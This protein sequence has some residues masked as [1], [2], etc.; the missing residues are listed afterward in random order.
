MSTPLRGVGVVITRPVGQAAVLAG[1][2][3]REGAT[4]VQLPLTRIVP[5]PPAEVD[6]AL[7]HVATADIVVVSSANG[8]T[9]L[10]DALARLATELPPAVTVAAV[11]RATATALRAAGLR[12]DVVPDG[13]TAA[14]LVAALAAH[15]PLSGRHALLAR[16]R[17]ARP[18]LPDGLVA[19]GAQVTDV[20]LYGVVAAALDPSVLH[21]AR[22]CPLWVFTAPSAVGAAIAATGLAFLQTVTLVS[23]GPTTSEY[24]RSLDLTPAAEASGRTTP[25][26]VD[27][28][29][30]AA[31]LM[32]T[33]G[34][35]G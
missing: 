4:V 16:A 8:A 2:L 34:H 27:A 14:T 30:T 22:A 19:A 28:V 11:G 3:D 12:V 32:R 29:R 7:T 21:A 23:I 6:A 26:L 31:R 18:E 10:A 15:V 1:A 25:D 9:L 5:V 35:D 13:A 17:N 20:A 24:L 33:A